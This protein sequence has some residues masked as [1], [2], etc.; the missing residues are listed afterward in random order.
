MEMM[1][2]FEANELRLY[3]LSS[4]APNISPREAFAFAP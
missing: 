4:T 2:R 1:S 3:A